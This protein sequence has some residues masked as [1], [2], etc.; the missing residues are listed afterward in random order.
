VTIEVLYID[1][2]PN[3]V[4]PVERIKEVLGEMNLPGEVIEIRIADPATTRSSRF[5]GSPTVMVNRVDVD[6]FGCRASGGLWI[7]GAAA[8]ESQDARCER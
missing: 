5:P 1:G 2:C 8:S 7:G 6:A 3:Y 4:P